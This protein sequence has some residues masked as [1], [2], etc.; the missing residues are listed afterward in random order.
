VTGA[1]APLQ[2]LGDVTR[3]SGKVAIVGYHQ[4]APREIPL[5]FWNWMAFRIAN[6]HFRD[7]DTILHGMETGMRLLRSGQISL[8][9]LVTHRFSLEEIG[10]AF[11]ASH[12]K[13]PGFTKATVC[14][15][16]TA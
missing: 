4:G 1:Q 3:M 2:L 10:A 14:M 11:E 15:D 5:G 13:P 7:V 9:G 12:A 6:C 16:G 8:D